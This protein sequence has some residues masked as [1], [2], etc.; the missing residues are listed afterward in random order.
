MN[1]PKIMTKS[2]KSNLIS[3]SLLCMGHVCLK[4]FFVLVLFYKALHLGME[5][6][7]TCVSQDVGPKGSVFLFK[8][9]KESEPDKFAEV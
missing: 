3:F 4:Y 9:P 6:K 5:T 1:S 8:S 7:D 2:F